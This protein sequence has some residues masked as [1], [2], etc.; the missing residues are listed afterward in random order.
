MSD[1]ADGL[2]Q[3]MFVRLIMRHDRAL[4]AYLRSLLPTTTDVDEVMQEVSVVA[5]RKFQELDDPENFR[6]W[7]CGIARY[8][9]LMYRRKKARDRHVLSEDVEQLLAD[10]GAEELGVRELQLGA[11]EQCLNKLPSD[12]KQLVMRVYAAEQPM[13]AIAEQLGKT[14]EALYQIL[15]RARRDL[16]SC[17]ERRL[18]VGGGA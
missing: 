18:A 13:K 2:N 8:E 5:W 3:D 1:K 17:V 12:R 15:S 14:P 11:L 6:R 10:E 7:V 4:R 9:V 16:L